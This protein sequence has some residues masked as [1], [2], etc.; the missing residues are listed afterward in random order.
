MN[1]SIYKNTPKY[2][3]NV[4]SYQQQKS[5]RGILCHNGTQLLTPVPVNAIEN[6][7]ID[8]SKNVLSAVSFLLQ[9]ILFLISRRVCLI[10]CLAC[11]CARVLC[12]FTCLRSH[13]LGVFACLRACVLGVLACLRASVFGVFGCLRACIRVLCLR[14]SYDACLAC[15]ALTYSFFCLVIYFVCINKG[16]AIKRKLLIHVNLSYLVSI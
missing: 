6:V 9:Q 13:V 16:F 11:L 10:A 1:L 2:K 4:S 14:A 5:I 8:F 15:L 12:M 3:K 7:L